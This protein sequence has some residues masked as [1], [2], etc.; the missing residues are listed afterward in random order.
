MS[1]VHDT[2]SSLGEK[3][4]HYS[5]RCAQQPRMYMGANETTASEILIDSAAARASKLC[6]ALE[7]A[8]VCS[9][10]GTSGSTRDVRS[11]ITYPR[12]GSAL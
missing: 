10:A 12:L 11:P 6:R 9:H 1:D 7:I 4:L 2:I 8:P 3:P 5:R